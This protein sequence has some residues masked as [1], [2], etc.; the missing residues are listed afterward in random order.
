MEEILKAEFSKRLLTR[1]T[2]CTQELYGSLKIHTLQYTG[3]K[4]FNVVKKYY[5]S[6]RED[7][8]IPVKDATCELVVR[9][10]AINTHDPYVAYYAVVPAHLILDEN[11]QEDLVFKKVEP[12]LVRMR[13]AGETLTTKYMVEVFNSPQRLDLRMDNP[14]FSYQH[15]GNY[16]EMKNGDCKSFLRDTALIEI[17]SRQIES[18]KPNSKNILLTEIETAMTTKHGHRIGHVVPL[19]DLKHLVIMGGEKP[20]AV[21]VGPSTGYLLPLC[22]HSLQ[23]K[24]GALLHHIQFAI[25][26]W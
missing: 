14:I 22:C 25:T 19:Y 4:K 11:E 9:A 26:D 10:E 20:V 8:W 13:K 12:E 3:E 5:Q 17:E 23:K 2:I 7:Q 6:K 15:Y 1:F 24:T 21:K 16:D 18:S